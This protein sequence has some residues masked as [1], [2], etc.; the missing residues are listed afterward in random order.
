MNL[1]TEIL[2]ILAKPYAPDKM[3][4]QRFGRHDLAFKTDGEGRPVLLLIGKAD[5][6]GHIKGGRFARRLQTGA[7]GRMVSNHWDN[8]GK[9]G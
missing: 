1:G 4:K 3:I 2:K 5:A 7:G 9:T 6:D 8:K